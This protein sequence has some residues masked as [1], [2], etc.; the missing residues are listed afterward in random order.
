MTDNKW[1]EIE[2]AHGIKYYRFIYKDLLHY[3]INNVNFIMQFDKVI[4]RFTKFFI[5]NYYNF[6]H[7]INKRYKL[8]Q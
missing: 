5:F 6:Y 4:I 3:I 8:I 1:L 2:G 7:S